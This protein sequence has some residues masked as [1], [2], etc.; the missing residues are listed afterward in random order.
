MKNSLFLILFLFTVHKVEAQ[1]FRKFDI[2]NSGC[3]AY[4]FCVPD[5]FDKAYSPDSSVVYTSDCTTGDETYGVIC[6]KLKTT[7][8]K[9]DDAVDVLIEYLDFLKKE[10]NIVSAAGYGKG[11]T[12]RNYDKARGVID[13]WVDKGKTEWKIKGWTDGKYMG[14]LYSY[15]SKEST[16]GYESKRDLFLESFRFPGM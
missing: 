10:V 11:H 12:M 3:Q 6:V 14:I 4:F 13:Y 1:N 2:S 9:P 7:I 15:T 5:T 8:D 16:S